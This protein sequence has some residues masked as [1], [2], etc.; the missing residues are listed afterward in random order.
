MAACSRHTRRRIS[1]SASAT[2]I[3]RM[4]WGQL[5]PHRL[6]DGG[7]A[8]QAVNDGV[9]RHVGRHEPDVGGVVR[10]QTVGQR[11]RRPAGVS[12]PVV[13]S[14][15]HALGGKAGSQPVDAARNW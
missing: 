14:R 3:E 2:P 1:A 15:A 8:G 7:I 12:S 11:P 4:K 9:E 10:G 6:V 13:A 5:V